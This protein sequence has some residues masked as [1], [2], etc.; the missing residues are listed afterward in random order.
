MNGILREEEQR[1]TH[2]T[3]AS[4][5]CDCKKVMAS[6]GNAN[7][8]NRLQKAVICRDF[9]L[10]EERDECSKRTASATPSAVPL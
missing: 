2:I 9:D 1:I 6:S 4:I 7:I 8:A 10:E 5:T 3:N